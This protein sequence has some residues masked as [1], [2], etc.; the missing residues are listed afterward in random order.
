MPTDRELSSALLDSLRTEVETT[1][2]RYCSESGQRESLVQALKRPG[3]ALHSDSRCRAGSLTIEVYRTIKGSLSQVALEAAVAVE[4]FIEAAFMFDDVADDEVDPDLNMNA[5]EYLAL[6]ITAINCASATATE[7]VRSAKLGTAR[8]AASLQKLYNASIMSS[9]GQFL[10]ARFETRDDV[11][12]DEALEMTRLKAGGCG[13][14][15]AEFGASIATEDDEV[16]EVFGAFGEDLCTYFQ[17]V[18]DLRDSLP[19][20]NR[21]GDIQSFKKTVPLAYL[22]NSLGTQDRESKSGSD[23]TSETF[24]MSDEFEATGARTFG[25]VVAESFMNR[26]EKDL[27]AISARFGKVD[28][29]ERL[30]NSAEFRQQEAPTPN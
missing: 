13:R 10:D 7:T 29:L 28:D 27:A 14:L 24:D 23:E 3:F 11:T 8:G 1:V 9:A 15:A 26:A 6:A 12:T 19:S 22:Y 30:L 25:A 20:G 18:D 17:L 21:K 4:L 5:A 16:V 2:S